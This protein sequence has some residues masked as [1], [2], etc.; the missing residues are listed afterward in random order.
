MRSAKTCDKRRLSSG[1]TTAPPSSVVEEEQVAAPAEAI[2][3]DSGS[4]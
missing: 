1:D 2:M 3:S 4:C